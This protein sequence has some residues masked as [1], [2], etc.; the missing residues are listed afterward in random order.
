MAANLPGIFVGTAPQAEYLL[1][2]SED[3]RGEFPVEEDFWVAAVEFADSVGIDVISS[4]LGYY[5]FDNISEYYSRDDVDGKTALTSQAA[6]IASLKGLLLVSSAG[7]EGN[8]EWEKVTFPADVENVLTVGSVSAEGQKSSFSS[9]G[10]T[11]DYRIKPDVMALGANCSVISPAG[12]VQTVNGTS[13]S[14]PMIAGL[15]ACLWQGFPLLKNTEIIQ[16]IRE[17][18]SQYQRPDAHLG[19]GIPDFIKA[20]NT[21]KNNGF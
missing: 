14:A 2:K 8:N 10:L 15:A 13:F 12:Q 7:N 5:K 18:S 9:V 1:I 19:Y 16:L 21:A 20:Y 17:S 4:S 3:T 11:A 6:E